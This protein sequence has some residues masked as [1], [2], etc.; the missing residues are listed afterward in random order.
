MHSKQ[1][2]Q[3]VEDGARPVITFTHAIKGQETC[4]EPGMRGRIVGITYK[5]GSPV[6]A[7][8]LE[9]FS[10]FNRPLESHDYFDANGKATLTAREA[11]YFNPREDIWGPEDGEIEEF[12]VEAGPTLA[13]MQRHQS[14]NT[15]KAYVQWLEQMVLE[16]TEFG[17][18][19]F[20]QF[21]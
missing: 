12:E 4:A 7:V 5:H 19:L 16:H 6:F 20:K 11:G 8:D 13:L 17:K 3:L 10:Q 15:G 21:N 1:L 18:A 14:E 9:E 2:A